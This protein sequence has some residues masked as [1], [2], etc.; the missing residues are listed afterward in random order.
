MSW[1]KKVEGPGGGKPAAE[2][3]KRLEREK[4]QELVGMQL[5]QEHSHEFC[6]V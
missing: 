5:Q 1:S 3:G 2:R 4:W 6:D